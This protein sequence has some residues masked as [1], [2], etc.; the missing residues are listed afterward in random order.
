MLISILTF[1][2]KKKSPSHYGYFFIRADS[3]GTQMY[4]RSTS[5]VSSLISSSLLGRLSSIGQNL[6]LYM[7]FI[8]LL[9]KISEK[10]ACLCDRLWKTRSNIL[11]RK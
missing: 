11:E 10:P 8:L 9:V 4:Y 5:S 6:A 3:D 2:K 1:K 7:V